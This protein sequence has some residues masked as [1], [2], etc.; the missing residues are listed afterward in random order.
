MSIRSTVATLVLAL[1]AGC[2]PGVY[3]PGAGDDDGVPDA[4]QA[5]PDA[6]PN[7][8][9]AAPQQQNCEPLAQTNQSGEHN[10]GTA[11]MT[12]HVQGGVGPAFTLGG[13]LYAS[14]QGGT[15][16]VGGT[17]I[18]K[19]ANNV[20]IKLVSAQNGNFWSTQAIAYPITVSASLCPDTIPMVSQ[21]AA[22]GDCNAA[23]CHAQ[24]APFG[25]V[26]VP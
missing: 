6:D 7:A 14:S 12:C 20:T 15:P 17:I 9:D 23:G 8:P 5:L 3:D 13:T 1:A 19:D 11:C 4:A 18:V 24:N 26:H 21:V 22:P 25:R 16:V 10:P 2:D